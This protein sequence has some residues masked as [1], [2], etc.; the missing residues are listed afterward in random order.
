MVMHHMLA[1]SRELRPAPRL[2][3]EITLRSREL[4]RREERER[5][6]VAGPQEPAASRGPVQAIRARARALGA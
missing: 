1:R 4:A 5:R 6:P 3:H 2:A